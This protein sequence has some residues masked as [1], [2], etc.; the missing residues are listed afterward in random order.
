MENNI[1]GDITNV[2]H[3]SKSLPEQVADKISHLIIE[4]RL[5]NGDKLPN[6]F[7]LAE[8]LN[9]SRG[10]VREAVKILVARNVLVLRRGKG[11]YIADNTGLI[12]DPFGFAYIEDQSRLAQELME[13]RQQLEPWI[14]EEAAKKATEEDIVEI[15]ELQYKV[16]ELIEEGQDYLKED[17]KLHT[18]IAQCTGNRVL[19]IL[20][21]VVTYSVHLFGKMTQ[22]SMLQE[23]IDVHAAIVDA[24]ANHEPEK[25]RDA[26]HQ[27]LR[28]H[29]DSIG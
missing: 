18:R 11:T 6:E 14:A 13:I 21:P 2:K 1:L 19:P 5:Q 10:S 24:I 12:D 25:A 29:K 8:K 22:K 3:S 4:H 9:V 27:H 16:E 23:T 17:Q 26:M 15:R 20:I 7:A 28:Y